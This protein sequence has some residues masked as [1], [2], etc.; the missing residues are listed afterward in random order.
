ME[1]Q[2]EQVS[3][4]QENRIMIGSA[5]LDKMKKEVEQLVKHRRKEFSNNMVRLNM[6]KKIE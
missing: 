6:L 5:C 3:I 4:E 1:K 2:T